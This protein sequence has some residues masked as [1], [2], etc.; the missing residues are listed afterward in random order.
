M[1]GFFKKKKEVSVIDKVYRTNREK[2]SAIGFDVEA[3]LAAGQDVFIFY[4]FDATKKWIEY[5]LS[6]K[7]IEFTDL[8]SANRATKVT[9]VPALEL[10]SSSRIKETLKRYSNP[11]SSQFLFANHYPMYTKEA[12]VLD[13]L[14]MLHDEAIIAACFYISLDDPLMAAFGSDRIKMLMDKMGYKEG[15]VI[16]HAMV[17]RSI[18]R[19]QQKLDSEIT[20]E[21]RADSQEDWF[22]RN[23]PNN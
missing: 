14:S 6:A 18:S 21:N 5:F 23:M 20:Y 12:N 11:E 4:Y 9:L 16:Q 13:D 8:E 3:F 10:T 7:G 15:E 19:A 17:T 2:E 1:F 22:Q